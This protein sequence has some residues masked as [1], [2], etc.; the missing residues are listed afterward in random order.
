MKLAD[1][2][3]IGIMILIMAAAI[4]AYRRLKKKGCSRCNACRDDCEDRQE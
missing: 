3:L 2:I 4:Y 1:M